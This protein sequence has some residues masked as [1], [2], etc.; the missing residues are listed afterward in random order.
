MKN[1]RHD[2]QMHRNILP[3]ITVS[4]LFRKGVYPSKYMDYWKKLSKTLL[5]EK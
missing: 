5:R 2:F 3:K 1:Q 4:L